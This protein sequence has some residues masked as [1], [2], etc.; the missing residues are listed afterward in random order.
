MNGGKLLAQKSLRL[1]DTLANDIK[2]LSIE[3]RVSENQI[4]VDALKLY[5]DYQYMNGK[6]SFIPREII[7][8]LQS[9]YKVA[10]NSINAKTNR[11]LSEVAIQTIIQNLILAKS[12]ELDEKDIY[13]YRLKALDFLKEN[14][15]ILKLDEI[16]E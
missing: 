7:N 3:L 8:V 1:D 9:S 5:R 2:K 11:V 16:V 4:V 13:R 15:R 12:L 6:A 10:E 14:Q